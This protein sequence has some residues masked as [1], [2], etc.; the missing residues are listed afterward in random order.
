MINESAAYII[1]LLITFI[2]CIFAFKTKQ[3]PKRIL[4]VVLFILYL[5][6]L[7]GITLFPI[8]YDQS[9]K[10]PTDVIEYRLILVPFTTFFNFLSLNNP[11]VLIVQIGGNVIMTMPFGFLLPVVAP[12]KSKRFYILWSLGLTLMIESTQFLTGAIFQIFYR[13]ADIDD[14]ILNF[15]GALLGLLL[16]RLLP[17][18][19]KNKLFS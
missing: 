2:W 1:G 16:F 11:F 6:C 3:P 9:L 5:T 17:A 13:T 14:V 4:W 10:R 12:E 19:I 18:K 8:I 7:A 15:I